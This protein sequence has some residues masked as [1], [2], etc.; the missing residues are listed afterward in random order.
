[1]KICR[2][3]QWISVIFGVIGML[4]N[5]PPV[6]AVSLITFVIATVGIEIIKEVRK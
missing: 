4:I 2:Y 5:M 3:Y 1:M 6:I